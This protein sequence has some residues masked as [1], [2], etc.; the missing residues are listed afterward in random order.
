MTAHDICDFWKGT[1]LWPVE[2]AGNRDMWKI[3]DCGLRAEQSNLG[4]R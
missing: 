2:F 3:W 4:Y 1:H